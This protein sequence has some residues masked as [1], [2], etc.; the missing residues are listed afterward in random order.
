M[1]KNLSTVFL[2]LFGLFQSL[3]AQ[4]T[5]KGTILDEKGNPI[6]AVNVILKG[7]GTGTV[8]DLDGKYNIQVPNENSI[9]EFSFIGYKSKSESVGN[10]STI[11]VTL[12]E[13]AELLDE[14]VVSALGFAQ[15][16]DQ[17]GSTYATVSTQD[18]V[19]SGETG[20]ING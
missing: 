11:D 12:E 15:K 1:F 8:S 18:V 20:L 17:M 3:N 19:R 16:K 4:Q 10:R 5:V 6:I 13:D 2:L 14:V 7:T 9:L